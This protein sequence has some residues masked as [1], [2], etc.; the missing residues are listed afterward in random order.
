[1][2]EY[3][4]RP[5]TQPFGGVGAD[6]RRGDA[7]AMSIDHHFYVPAGMRD[8]QTRRFSEFKYRSLGELRDAGH[9]PPTTRFSLRTRA[10]A[11][12]PS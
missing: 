10:P 4:Y 2:A 7:A 12:Q 9:R 1:M 11:T 5:G 6:D 8:S 3:G